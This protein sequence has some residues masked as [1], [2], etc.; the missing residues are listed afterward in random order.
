MLRVNVCEAC[1]YSRFYRETRRILWTCSHAFFIF[2]F[3]PKYAVRYTFQV[4]EGVPLEELE[5]VPTSQIAYS[6]LLQ[7]C[8]V[9]Y[10]K[11][12]PLLPKV[13]EDV[14]TLLLA[15]KVVEDMTYLQRPKLQ[16]GISSPS[17]SC[18]GCAIPSPSSPCARDTQCCVAHARRS[19]RAPCR[20][21]KTIMVQRHTH[22]NIGDWKNLRKELQVFLDRVA[23]TK[24]ISCTTQQ[25]VSLTPQA[26]HLLK[27]LFF[28]TSNTF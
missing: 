23:G 26:Y 17:K 22:K 10:Y 15:L 18:R 2:H 8:R 21:R 6:P 20:G 9:L 1:V 14:H 16:Q 4:A 28:Y 5:D 3:A 19:P 27:S 24:T 12:S 7:N 13:V 11:T 25:H